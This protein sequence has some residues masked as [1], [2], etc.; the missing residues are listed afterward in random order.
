MLLPPAKLVS[1]IQRRELCGSTFT[2]ASTQVSR[3]LE[4]VLV[5]VVWTVWPTEIY[6][7][8]N[9]IGT[10]FDIEHDDDASIRRIVGR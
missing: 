4:Q 2:L 1:I 7:V 3:G 10:F 6:F 5:A 8:R 9:S